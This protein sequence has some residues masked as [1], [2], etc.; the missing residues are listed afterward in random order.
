MFELT[1]VSWWH[2]CS[3][4]ASCKLACRL[5]SI[6]WLVDMAN[7]YSTSANSGD[8]SSGS[9]DVPRN[10]ATAAASGCQDFL[11]FLQARPSVL[12][13]CLVCQLFCGCC[14]LSR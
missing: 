10:R 14:Y 4:T 11:A 5:F 2:V 8:S 12:I 1:C 3:V 9:E 13:L 6:E 7:F